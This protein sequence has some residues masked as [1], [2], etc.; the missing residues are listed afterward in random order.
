MEHGI[1]SGICTLSILLETK[2]TNVANL[3]KK[4]GGRRT[5]PALLVAAEKNSDLNAAAA[6]LLTTYYLLVATR[7]DKLATIECK[8]FV[9]RRP[10][11]ST[12][13]RALV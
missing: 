9:V 5:E 11:F 1:E 6:F 2:V 3:N 8:W 12:F 4:G 7:L 13:T 10:S